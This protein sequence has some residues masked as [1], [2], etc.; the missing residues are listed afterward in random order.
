MN[1]FYFRP[2]WLRCCYRQWSTDKTKT[3][4]NPNTTNRPNKNITNY[5]LVD[6][7]TA[8]ELRKALR[9][10]LCADMRILR[11]DSVTEIAGCAPTSVLKGH[12]LTTTTSRAA[13]SSTETN[14]SPGLLAPG[15]SFI[16][17]KTMAPGQ[18]HPFF[19][20]RE[21]KEE[22]WEAKYIE[23]EEIAI[24]KSLLSLP[25]IAHDDALCDSVAFRVPCR[26]REDPK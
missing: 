9:S 8:P 25:V 13:W 17:F 20:K 1:C 16:I 18:I 24:L 26:S 3:K 19:K 15:I 4:Q 12:Q 10:L 23:V 14:R 22:N 7:T 21:K 11:S 6:C 5:L 2:W